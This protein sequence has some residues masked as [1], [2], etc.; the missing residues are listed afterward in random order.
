MSSRY[1]I[2]GCAVLFGILFFSAPPNANAEDLL[3]IEDHEAETV[4]LFSYF[5]GNGEDGLHLAFSEDGLTWESLNFDDSFLRPEISD[6]RLM[7]DPSITR[8][9]D[10][11]FHMVWTTSW[12][13]QTIGHASSTDLIHWS[14][15]Q[16][17]D[18]MTHIPT[19]RNSWAPEIFYDD[20]SEQY[21][22]V[23]SSTIPERF[24]ETADS[25]ESGLNHRAYYTTTKDF[26]SFTPTELFFDPGF[27]VIDGFIVPVED[28]YRLVYKDETVKP[29]ACKNLIVASADSVLGPYSGQR[30]PIS[31]PGVWVEGPSVLKVGDR[32]LVYFDC[33]RQHRYGAVATTDWETWTDVSDE[34]SFPEGARHGTAFPVE[35]EIVTRI[36]ELLKQ[37]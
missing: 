26:E 18:V 25:C 13:N 29:E 2:F 15:Q 28:G 21:V 9:P 1:C 19:T 36:E 3:S 23:W 10:G 8:A 24:P 22:I 37:D 4:Y 31:P 7:R 35:R 6:D 12:W 32:W 34:V 17:I 30:E 33:Y 27:A 11:T 14:E 16:P 20:R 5:K